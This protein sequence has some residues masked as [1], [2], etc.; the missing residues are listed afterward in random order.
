MCQFFPEGPFQP[1]KKENCPRRAAR[2]GRRITLT[3][4]HA[5]RKIERKRK[6]SRGQEWPYPLF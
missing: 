5:W 3:P 4:L 1:V 6:G 2:S